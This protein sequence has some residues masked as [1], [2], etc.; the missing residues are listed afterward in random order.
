MAGA[1]NGTIFDESYGVLPGAPW[2]TKALHADILV[3]LSSTAQ[4]SGACSRPPDAARCCSQPAAALPCYRKFAS[5]TGHLHLAI[6]QA[7]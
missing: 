2:L 7:Y 5:V 4:F 1:A 3:H 6:I